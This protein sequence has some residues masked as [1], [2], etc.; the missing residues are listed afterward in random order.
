MAFR[1]ESLLELRVQSVINLFEVSGRFSSSVSNRAARRFWDRIPSESLVE[2]L[3]G[4]LVEL[5]VEAVT[6]SLLSLRLSF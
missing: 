4:S 2:I 6:E 5:L 1:T 3:G